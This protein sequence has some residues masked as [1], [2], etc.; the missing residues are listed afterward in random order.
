MQQ[1]EAL[2][3]K[4]I[5]AFRDG[6]ESL[7][8]QADSRAARNDLFEAV[9]RK[10]RYAMQGRPGTCCRLSCVSRRDH[11]AQHIG[12]RDQMPTR[13]EW[14]RLHSEGLLEGPQRLFS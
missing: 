7:R 10:H 9:L 1:A 6:C 8:F 4:Q 2:S 13:Q 3:L 14:W 5:Q 12:H 11:E